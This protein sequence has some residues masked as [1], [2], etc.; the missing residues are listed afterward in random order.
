MSGHTSKSCS[1]NAN[2]SFIRSQVQTSLDNGVDDDETS[3]KELVR[4][5]TSAEMK[6]MEVEFMQQCR[7]YSVRFALVDSD[8][9]EYQY[10]FFVK[11][12]RTR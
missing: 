12:Q 6:R 9:N 10:R 8:K 4:Y 5:Y 1:S 7:L 3:I 2:L 11:S